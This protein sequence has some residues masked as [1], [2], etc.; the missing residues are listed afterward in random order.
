MPPQARDPLLQQRLCT[1][2]T[3][4]TTAAD[5]PITA[6]RFLLT[7]G[8]E[9]PASFTVDGT[10]YTEVIFT[11]LHPGTPAMALPQALQER[12]GLLEGNRITSCREPAAHVC[13]E[14]LCSAH[15]PCCDH[16]Y[17]RLVAVRSRLPLVPLECLLHK[18]QC[19]ENGH[20]LGRFSLIPWANMDMVRE[21]RHAP[22]V[23]SIIPTPFETAIT[24]LP[25][26]PVRERLHHAESCHNKFK[27]FEDIS[28]G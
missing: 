20:G 15:L 7:G 3:G 10:P 18:C 13:Q 17:A 14:L 28:S 21:C 26:N 22:M 6:C 9:D 12:P 1:Q 11:Y 4:E 25:V 24:I 16:I 8:C 5:T 27:R 2:E 23:W 19:L